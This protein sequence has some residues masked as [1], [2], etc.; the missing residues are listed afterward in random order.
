MELEKKELI[1]SILVQNEPSLYEIEKNMSLSTE[2][3][4]KIIHSINDQLVS[5]SIDVADGQ[6]K[7]SAK[8]RDELY[9]LL[10]GTDD[11]AARDDVGFRKCLIE[12]ELMTHDAHHTLQTLS[13]KF[14]VSRNTMYTDMKQIKE[15]LKVQQLEISFSRKTG[16]QITGSEYLLR[17]DLVQITR[18]L[19]K[20]F[21]GRSCL[22]IFG[23][24][25]EDEHAK[26]KERLTLIE[27]KTQIRLT[28]E[29]REELPFILAVLMNRI[30]SYPA[31]WTFK[32][33][34]YDIRNTVEF[35]II[36]HCLNDFS[37]LK[38]VDILYL[39]LHILSSNRIES[40]FDFLNSEEILSAV[41]QF[42]EMLKN[43]LAVQFVKETE[44][45][46]KLLLHV[47]PAIFRN[48]FGFRINNPLTVRFMNEHKEIYLCV[49]DAV[50]PFERIVGHPLS[51]E[52]IVYLAMLVLGWLYQSKENRTF[53]F[54]A[55]VLCPNGTS[56][57]KLLLE[58]LRGMFP[59][60]EFIGAFSFRQFEQMN[61]ALD[62]IFTTK[63]I[64]SQAR[65]IVVPPFLEP[66]SR[67][68]LR[69]S[70]S[71]MMKSDASIQAK[72]ALSAIK[73]L[74][75]EDKLYTAETLLK[76]YFE[77]NKEFSPFL[78]SR[79]EEADFSEKNI[80]FINDPVPWTDC[81][82]IVFAPILG[83]KT[84]D[85]DYLRRCKAVFYKNYRQMLIGP[86]IYL[87]H[88]A[89]TGES[90]RPDIELAFFRRP[91]ADPDG[92]SVQIMVG[93]VPSKTNRH[94]PLLLML[95]D[96]FIDRQAR[97]Q[98]IHSKD[99]SEAIG[100]LKGGEAVG[101]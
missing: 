44:F 12:L 28:D 21:Y 97:E 99:A 43:R 86:N 22:S 29:Q 20:S 40:A 60:I 42:V 98:L 2:Q 66:E 82:D 33:E 51:N 80:L 35:P 15:D 7:I 25:N 52:E 32:I 75:P 48:L 53:Y 39:S 64:R 41:D 73:G 14:Y 93:L 11:F 3:I 46:E 95:N 69:A 36:K 81:L 100:I 19:L 18:H 13:D 24:V 59:Q 85:R 37:F 57:S 5:G 55:A 88:T 94:V 61:V 47:Q 87:P 4:L 6:L 34:K 38:D 10:I 17:N 30:R 49:A 50:E 23:F 58:N 101:Y 31:P 90:L 92:N 74:L 96:V 70:V 76:V 9:A 56:V 8:C 89:P 68:R 71:R 1:E 16:Y 83:R 26:L 91:V 45:K 62:F 27:E 67:K 77:G 84:A 78:A 79:S 65:T 72:S 63:P 54:K